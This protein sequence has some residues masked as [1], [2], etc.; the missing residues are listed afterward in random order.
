MRPTRSRALVGSCV[1]GAVAVAVES[2]AAPPAL[3]VALGLMMVFVVPGFAASCVVTRRP[4]SVGESL[5]AS[6]GTSLAITI[7]VSVLLAATPVGLTRGSLADVLGGSTIILSVYAWRRTRPDRGV[8][9]GR[10]S[11][12]KMQP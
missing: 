1:A 9:P 11:T 5:L 4:L 10:E 6:L 7:C 8:Q 2:F 3:R 12:S